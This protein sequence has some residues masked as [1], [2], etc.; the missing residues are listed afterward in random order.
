MKDFRIWIDENKCRL[1]YD[2]YGL[3]FDSYRCF[4]NDIDRPAYLLAYQGLMQYIRENILNNSARPNGIT[5]GEW[6]NKYLKLLRDDNKWDEIV[7]KCTQQKEDVAQHKD[8]IMNLSNEVRDKFPLWRQFRNICAHYKGY[9]L[10]KAH[11]LTLYSF[12]EQY[13]FSLHALGGVETLIQQFDDFYNPLITSEH[14]DIKP[15]LDKIKDSVNEAEYNKFFSEVH[16]ICSKHG[17][18][19]KNRFYEF[20]HK[21]ITE[22]SE[23]V[24]KAVINFICT[25]D[26]IM[27]RFLDTYPQDCLQILYNY[28]DTH[29]FWYIRLPNL[30]HKLIILA[31]LLDSG[32]I[33]DYDQEQAM[34]KCLSASENL[35]NTQYED[36][37]KEILDILN[38]KGYFDLFLDIFFNRSHTAYH[39]DSICYR[40]DFYIDMVNIM[41]WNEKYVSNLIDVFRNLPYPYT[42][43]DRMKKMYTENERYKKTIDDICKE[44][45]WVLPACIKD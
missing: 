26:S 11:T 6:E 43:C 10:N 8:A 37:P 27:D 3:F 13:L 40:T 23:S 33:P 17:G 44:K 24:R 19:F 22:C 9:D 7:F 31:L 30:R 34:R 4:I 42:L 5:E 25:D 12:I 20:V 41:R 28:K 18:Y 14:A 39:Y 15:L 2:V 45:N 36:I 29:N 16:K 38:D 35:S 32:L 1:S 21:V